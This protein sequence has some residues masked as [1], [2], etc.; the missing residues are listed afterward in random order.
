MSKRSPG[1]KA[2]AK[3]MAMHTGEGELP[4]DMMPQDVFLTGYAQG[5]KRGQRVMLEKMRKRLGESMMCCNYDCRVVLDLHGELD[6]LE[7]EIGK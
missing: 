5:S 2:L 3:F 4:E 7:A 1:L 6:Q